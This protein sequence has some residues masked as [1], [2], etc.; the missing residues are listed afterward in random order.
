MVTTGTQAHH[1]GSP[2][3]THEPVLPDWDHRSLATDTHGVAHSYVAAN[4][5]L[6][7][8]RQPQ[9]PRERVARQPLTPQR[10]PAPPQKDPKEASSPSRQ[11]WA[12]GPVARARPTYQ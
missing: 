10:S 3:D 9:T 4:K 7:P 6:P 2:R 11:S 1:P 5:V 12:G 8:H